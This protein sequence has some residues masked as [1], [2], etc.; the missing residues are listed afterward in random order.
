MSTD[1]RVPNEIWLGIAKKGLKVGKKLKSP[2]TGCNM[3]KSY[4]AGQ[5]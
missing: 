1:T 2:V 4:L 3:V 5:R